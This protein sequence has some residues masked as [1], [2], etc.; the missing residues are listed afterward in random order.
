MP[1]KESSG[2]LMFR[3]RDGR[4]EVLLG[5]PG[6]P[7]WQTRDHGAWTIPKGGANPGEA[8]VDAAV[9]EF[10]EE[11]GFDVI[12]P[13][14]PLGQITQRSGKIVHAWAFEGDCEPSAINSATTTTEWPP[15]SGRRIEIPEVD[16][17][18]FFSADA[19]KRVINV[20]QAELVDRLLSL[21]ED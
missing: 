20:A 6:G 14:L 15:R 5:H 3:R 16:R 4:V 2:L 8:F 18:E 21:I 17:L 19:G 13:L 1:P 11:T 10:Q 7:F 12:P 9:R